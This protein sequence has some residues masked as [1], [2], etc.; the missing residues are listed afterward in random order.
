MQITEINN[1]DPREENFNLVFRQVN[2]SNPQNN[3]SP[4]VIERKY[5]VLFNLNFPGNKKVFFLKSGMFQITQILV[6]ENLK[7]KSQVLCCENKDKI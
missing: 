7:L 6:N 3:W 2:L 4:V 1:K 5:N